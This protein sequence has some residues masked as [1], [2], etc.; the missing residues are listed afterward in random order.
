[1]QASKLQIERYFVEE[2]AFRLRE[3]AL[4]KLEGREAVLESGDIDIEVHLGENKNDSQKR[5]CQLDIKL[6]ATTARKFPYAFKVVIVGFFQLSDECTSE[7]TDVLMT[8]SAPSMLY[9]AAREYLL[10]ITGRTRYL[11]LMLPTVL[12][13]PKQ[14]I[15]RKPKLS[16]KRTLGAKKS[17]PKTT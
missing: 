12:F 5:F 6:K 13:V 14:K 4:Q 7:E 2:A 17:T 1:M 10:T 8:N 15:I 3:P 11:P 16:T 9:T